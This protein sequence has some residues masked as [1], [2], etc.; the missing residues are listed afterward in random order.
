MALSDNAVK[1]IFH[2][3]ADQTAGREIVDAVNLGAASGTQEVYST[4]ALIVATNVS[5]T[6]DFGS[7]KVGDRVIMIPAVAGNSV[8]LLVATAGTLPVAAIVGNSYLVFRAFVA[9]PANTTKL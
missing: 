9:D 2:A 6:I 7:L 8:S 5:Q 4:P 1:R 3:V